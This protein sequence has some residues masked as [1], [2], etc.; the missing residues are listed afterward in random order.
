MTL[1][2]VGG[3]E[4]DQVMNADGSNQRALS[5]RSSQWSPDGSQVAYPIVDDQQIAIWV[6]DADGGNDHLVAANG[7]YCNGRLS[8]SPDGTMLAY[9]TVNREDP[10]NVIWAV[11]V[12]NADGSNDREVIGDLAGTYWVERVSWS[13]DSSR[14]VVGQILYENASN[15]YVVSADGS[16]STVLELPADAPSS[17]PYTPD[18]SPVADEI[19]FST[20]FG[21]FVINA[22]GLSSDSSRTIGGEVRYGHPT[23]SSLPGRT[24]A[25]VVAHHSV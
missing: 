3:Q 15:L 8:W 20:G 14:L 25:L 13:P 5:V 9:C 21:I 12:V 19:A 2:T 16:G 4:N 22:D 10:D 6:Q 18:W 1:S 17:R 23:V 24:E 7:G 11:H